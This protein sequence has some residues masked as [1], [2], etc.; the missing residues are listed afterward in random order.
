MRSLDRDG[1]ESR[2]CFRSTVL[3]VFKWAVDAI[4]TIKIERCYKMVTAFLV[5]FDIMYCMQTRD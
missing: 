2:K 5:D 1:Q 3:S 4:M